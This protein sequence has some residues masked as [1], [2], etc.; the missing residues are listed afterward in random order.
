MKLVLAAIGALVLIVGARNLG[1]PTPAASNAAVP[2][3]AAQAAKKQTGGESAPD[4]G[5]DDGVQL[6]G[7]PAERAGAA[8]K[9]AVPGARVNEIER[10]DSGSGY[11]VE[12]IRPDGS[13]VDVVLDGSFNVIKVV[14]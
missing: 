8:A 4:K 14:R 5:K 1:T 9:A 2:A 7:T 13:V 12:L 6:H 3:A 11:E 10:T